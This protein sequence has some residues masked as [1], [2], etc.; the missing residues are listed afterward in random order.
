MWGLTQQTEPI[1]ISYGSPSYRLH[2]CIYIVHLK[3]RHKNVNIIIIRLALK[4]D[5]LL[6]SDYS[7]CVCVCARVEVYVCCVYEFLQ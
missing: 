4:Y 6:Y 3:I 1:N 2:D 5:T 7:L